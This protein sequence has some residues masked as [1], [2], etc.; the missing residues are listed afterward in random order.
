MDPRD[1]A[2]STTPAT[3]GTQSSRDRYVQ[4]RERRA[5]KAQAKERNRSLSVS[6]DEPR[7]EALD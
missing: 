3:I 6:E 7:D 2:R 4:A 1:H 5:R